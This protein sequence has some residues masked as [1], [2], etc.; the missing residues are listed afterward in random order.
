MVV[1]VVVRWGGVGGWG[2][3]WGGVGRGG[4]CRVGVVVGRGDVVGWVLVGWVGVW[5]VGWGG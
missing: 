5:V 2:W 1:W 4:D 3:W